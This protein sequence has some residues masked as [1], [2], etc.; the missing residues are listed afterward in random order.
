MVMLTLTQENI[1]QVLALAAVLRDRADVFHFNR[2]S[3]TGE[4][5]RLYL[6]SRERFFT[7]L[8]EYLAAAKTNPV[9]GMKESLINTCLYKKGRCFSAGAPAMGAEPP[10]ILS[11]CCLTGRSMHA[12]SSPP[13]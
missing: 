2:L 5:A 10:S 11:P 8:E 1:D 12:E 7:F 3:M 6:P 4:G 9:I 13:L